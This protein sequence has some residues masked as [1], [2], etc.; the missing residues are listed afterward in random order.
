MEQPI[1]QSVITFYILEE[2]GYSPPQSLAYMLQAFTKAITQNCQF[3]TPKPIRWGRQ[4]WQ[5]WWVLCL[6]STE[7]TTSPI[8]QHFLRQLKKLTE[9]YPRTKLMQASI[10]PVTISPRHPGALAP[11]CVPSPRV[12]AQQKMPGG[13]AHK[14]RCPWGRAFAS[15]RFQTW[16][17]VNTVIWA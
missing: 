7:L 17:V 6:C 14:W 9:S 1:N 10:W 13:R 12:F 4:N 11:K 8:A 16:K 2:S 15:A 3:R 5:M